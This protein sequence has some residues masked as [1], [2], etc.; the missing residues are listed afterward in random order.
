MRASHGGWVRVARLLVDSDANKDAKDDGGNTALVLASMQG[1][2]DVV[3]LLADGAARDSR[4]NA[5]NTP[6]IWAAYR[7]HGKV[8]QLLLEAGASTDLVD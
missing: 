6:L 5:G 3:E 8:V 2:A 1:H 7:G 4:D